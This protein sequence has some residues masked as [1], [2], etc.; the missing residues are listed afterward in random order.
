MVKKWMAKT[1]NVWRVSKKTVL[2]GYKKHCIADKCILMD[3]ESFMAKHSLKKGK[4]YKT[5]LCL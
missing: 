3:Q 5:V 1:L 4:K 2:I